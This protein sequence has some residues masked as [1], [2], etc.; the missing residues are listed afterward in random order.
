MAS[1]TDRVYSQSE[2]LVTAAEMSWLLRIDQNSLKLCSHSQ[3]EQP[4][5]GDAVRRRVRL[6]LR[7]H[8]QKVRLVWLS[9]PPSVWS[10]SRR[11]LSS[12]MSTLRRVSGGEANS[13]RRLLD[14][15]KPFTLL[16]ILVCLQEQK[17]C[18]IGWSDLH[19]TFKSIDGVHV[20]SKPVCRALPY[21]VV[22][23]GETRARSTFP[24]CWKGC[25]LN[26]LVKRRKQITSTFVG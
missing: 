3:F 24:L 15:G 14:G 25:L 21:L 5:R 17:I 6:S 4:I 22:I 1:E 10:H 12:P 11:Y 13:S 8:R 7:Y 2:Q 16:Q 19:R 23:S 26:A 9:R 18:W 20:S